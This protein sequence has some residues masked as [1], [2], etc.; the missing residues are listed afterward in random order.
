MPREKIAFPLRF[1]VF[2]RLKRPDWG[3]EAPFVVRL[4]RV[5]NAIRHIVESHGT[6]RGVSQLYVLT[7]SVGT[8]VKSEKIN[9]P[10]LELF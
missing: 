5:A 7:P 4:G 10:T 1:L 3:A 6:M 9:I 8:R 2:R